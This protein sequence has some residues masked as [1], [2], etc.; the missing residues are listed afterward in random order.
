MDILIKKL[1]KIKAQPIIHIGR[2]SVIL[3]R[4]FISGYLDREMELNPNFKSVFF[5]FY[6]FIRE[7]Y[8]MAPNLY[9]DRILTAYSRTDEDA[10]DLFYSHLDEFLA[11]KNIKIPETKSKYDD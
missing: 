1:Y 10:F 5:D 6:D 8:K 11:S 7:Y 9:W 2:K 4:V 3:L